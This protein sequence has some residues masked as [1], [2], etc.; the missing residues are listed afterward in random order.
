[1]LK[2][3]T[4]SSKEDSNQLYA[5]ITPPFSEEKI[6]IFQKFCILS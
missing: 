4:F 3:H 2:K 1:M 5:P 6:F